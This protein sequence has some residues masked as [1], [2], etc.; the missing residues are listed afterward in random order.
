MN[1]IWAFMILLGIGVGLVTGKT[2]EISTALVDSAKSGVDY[3]LGMAGVVA[4]WSGVMRLAEAEG[5]MELLSEKMDG[6]LR[7]LFPHIPENHPSKHYIAGNFAANILGLG[8][9]STPTGLSAMEALQ[10][11]EEERRRTKHPLALEKGV[12]SREMCTF[13]V[14]NVSSLQ[15]IPMTII[16]YRSQFGAQM[17]TAIVLPAII[18]TSI[19]TLVGLIFVKW[20]GRRP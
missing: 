9:A 20:M 12:A 11:L 16:A 6:V 5:L 1:R 13:L 15:L 10:Q 14:I 4:M 19:S 2:A 17:P 3:A 8:W 18:A 7:F